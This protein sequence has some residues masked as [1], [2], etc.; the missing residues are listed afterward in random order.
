MSG[1]NNS[2]NSHSQPHSRGS[3]GAKLVDE[4]HMKTLR[5]LSTL[6]GNRNCFE[7]GQRAPNY[8]DVTIGSFICMTC[9]GL[10]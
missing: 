10:L 6:P 4:S 8:V 2:K 3:A 1:G 7:C 9:S 5:E